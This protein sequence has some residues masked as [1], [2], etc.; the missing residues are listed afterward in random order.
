MLL[1]IIWFLEFSQQS[2]EVRRI[3]HR[4]P[5]VNFC[6]GQRPVGGHHGD[7]PWTV[8]RRLRDAR[9]HLRHTF[10][11]LG[12]IAGRM[13]FLHFSKVDE[14]RQSDGNDLLQQKGI[15]FRGRIDGTRNSGF[16]SVHFYDRDRTLD[17]ILLRA[18]D[19]IS[20]RRKEVDSE[21]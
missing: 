9:R 7:D 14:S 18:A 21:S 1:L 11:S 3:I 4:F 13:F 10:Q 17:Q 20:D 16:R 19:W 15:C 8:R 5:K 6:F 2:S 12:T